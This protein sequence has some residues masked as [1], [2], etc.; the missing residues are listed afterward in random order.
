MGMVISY[1]RMVSEVRTVINGVSCSA[2]RRAL[3]IDYLLYSRAFSICSSTFVV[4][5]SI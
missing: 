4:F 1:G 2:G 5:G 3:S